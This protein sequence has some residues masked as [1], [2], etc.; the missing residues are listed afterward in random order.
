MLVGLLYGFLFTRFGVP[1][2]V[3]TLAGLLGFLGLQLWVLGKT[4]SIN[5]PFDSWIVQFAQQW[6]LPD[7]LSYVLVVLTV[8]VFAAQ[9]VF[10]ARRRTKAELTAISTTSIVARSVGL[11]VVLGVPTWYL[12]QARGVGLMFLL[13]LVLV[14]V[15]NFFL[16]RT[17]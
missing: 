14:V 15:M 8:L 6:F 12:N 3:I 11:L 1:S 4:G 17:R 16:L 10:I 7:W 2:F 5:I 13:F 9:L